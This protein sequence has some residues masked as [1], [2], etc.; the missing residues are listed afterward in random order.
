LMRRW[1]LSGMV[2][3]P[4]DAPLDLILEAKAQAGARFFIIRDRV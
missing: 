2:G 4:E 3:D 1:V